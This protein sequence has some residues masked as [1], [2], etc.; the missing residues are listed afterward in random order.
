MIKNICKTA[1]PLE[2]LA[3]NNSKIVE[4]K[5]LK[6]I[7]NCFKSEECDQILI[8]CTL[9]NTILKV[10]DENE[11]FGLLFLELPLTVMHVTL[12]EIRHPCLLDYFV[13]QITQV[14]GP[15]VLSNSITVVI[16]MLGP[17][18]RKLRLTVSLGT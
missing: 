14:S 16:K 6:Y 18:A 15:L 11:I 5:L 17:G 13:Y 4:N 9:F 2:S 7:V 12:E 1:I 3:E 10:L 8:N